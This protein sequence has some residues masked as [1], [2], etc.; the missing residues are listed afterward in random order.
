MFTLAQ[1]VAKEV[2]QQKTRDTC[3]EVKPGTLQQKMLYNTNGGAE[4]GRRMDERCQ[5]KKNVSATHRMV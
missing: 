5:E 4:D 3:L 2:N 1:S